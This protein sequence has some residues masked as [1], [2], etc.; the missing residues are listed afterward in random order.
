MV[1][2]TPPSMLHGKPYS[3]KGFPRWVQ[4]IEKVSHGKGLF[5]G[6]VGALGVSWVISV[7]LMSFNH[8]PPTMTADNEAKHVA[9]M[10]FNNVNPVFGVSRN[11]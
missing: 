3:Y 6:C 2:T 1:F 8:L 9:W 10:K 7:L 5:I 11:N 4:N